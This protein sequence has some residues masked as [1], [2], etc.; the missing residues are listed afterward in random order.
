MEIS[1]NIITTSNY[2]M[3]LKEN[4][5]LIEQLNKLSDYFEVNVLLNGGDLLDT[6]RN[7]IT[8]STVYRH[9]L[10]LTHGKAQQFL[11]ENTKSKYY[12]CIDEDDQFYSVEDIIKLKDLP[13]I[14]GLIGFNYYINEKGHLSRVENTTVLGVANWNF[15]WNK[16]DLDKR[17]LHRFNMNY[18]DDSCFY[19][20]VYYSYKECTIIT[21][22]LYQHNIDN[23]RMSRCAINVIRDYISQIYQDLHLAVTK[24]ITL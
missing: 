19:I 3:Q 12:L 24:R 2:G 18:Y 5:V 21:N 23:S 14:E 11:H 13:D 4:S 20:P 7:P 15:L 17:N 8:K 16:N 10:V 6:S 1:I 22:C 9:S